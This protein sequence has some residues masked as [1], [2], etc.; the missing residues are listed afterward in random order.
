MNDPLQLMQLV[1]W[2][3]PIAVVLFVFS[4][5][6]GRAWNFILA[7]YAM[8][9]LRVNWKFLPG[10]EASLGF[11]A[12]RYWVGIGAIVIITLGFMD[13]FVG[14]LTMENERAERGP[15]AL[16]AG[17][18]AMGAVYLWM[19]PPVTHEFITCMRNSED[20]VWVIF[21]FITI[22]TIV[23]IRRSME[24]MPLYTGFRML[25]AVFC[26]IILWRGIGF[27]LRAFEFEAMAP[28]VYESWHTVQEA[29][30]ALVGLGFGGA[31]TY[32]LVR[33]KVSG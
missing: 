1:M 16:A 26:M 18:L 25:A 22:A 29:L 30:E 21:S 4:W 28:D 12:M 6:S 14:T 24:G 33:L 9:C 20:I 23:R 3:I 8:A 19:S 15:F 5:R 27:Q 32:I 10:Y 7:G 17:V 13:F 2:V 31:F 11:E